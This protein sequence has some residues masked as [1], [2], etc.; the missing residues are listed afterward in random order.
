MRDGDTIEVGGLPIRLSGLA[1]PEGDEPG[2]AGASKAMEQLVLGRELRCELDGE[3]THD[4]CAG[5]CYLNGAD[6]AALMVRQR[7]RPCLSQVTP[8]RYA[9]AERQA[10]SR[11]QRSRQDTRCRG[12][13]RPGDRWSWF[14]AQAAGRH[15][16]LPAR[17]LTTVPTPLDRYAAPRPHQST[18][19]PT[20][21]R[22]RV[23]WRT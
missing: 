15:D 8:R 2:G 5:I 12:T 13:A 18:A 14:L 6:I 17:E 16:A 19:T 1:A 3:R 4:R 21:Q 11:G 9:E 7:S 20:R 22:G 10:A 23:A